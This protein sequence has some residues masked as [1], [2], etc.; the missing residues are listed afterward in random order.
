M[1]PGSSVPPTT[2]HTSAPATVP[3]PVQDSRHAAWSHLDTPVGQLLLTTDG[4]ALTG[5]WFERHRDGGDD[6]PSAAQ[7]AGTR[8]D[9]HPVLAAARVQFEEYFA[10]ERRVFA[11]PLAPAG[12]AFQTRVWNAL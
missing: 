11:L 12:T 8:D 7:R 3:A 5:V 4:R 6:R 10:R 2:V 1:S 9:D